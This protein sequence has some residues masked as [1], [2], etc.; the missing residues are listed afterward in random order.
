MP[1]SRDE[2]VLLKAVHD[3]IS[4]RYYLQDDN[5]TGSDSLT[6]ADRQ[7]MLLPERIAA[8][9]DVVFRSALSKAVRNAVR[10]L[11][12]AQILQYTC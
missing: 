9:G 4:M 11:F 7:L 5:T 2:H 1:V 8:Y 12:F 10:V 6:C 3:D